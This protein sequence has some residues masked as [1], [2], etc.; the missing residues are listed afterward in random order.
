MINREAE[1]DFKTAIQTLLLMP[2]I[3]VFNL[4]V[5]ILLFG[6]WFNGKL[7]QAH[8]CHIIIK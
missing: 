4:L 3:I 7:I 1:E 8:I 2:I 6:G 5:N